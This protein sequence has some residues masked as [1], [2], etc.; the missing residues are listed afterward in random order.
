MTVEARSRLSKSGYSAVAGWVKHP[1]VR[2]AAA[3]FKA[4]FGGLDVDEDTQTFVVRLCMTVYRP[5]RVIGASPDLAEAL[6]PAQAMMEVDAEAAS[7]TRELTLSASQMASATKLV[8]VAASVVAQ[9][10]SNGVPIDSEHAPDVLAFLQLALCAGP[11]DWD[12]SGGELASRLVTGGPVLFTDDGRSM[13]LSDYAST[14]DTKDGDSIRVNE[15]RGPRRLP[16]PYAGGL[17]SRATTKVD[18]RRVALNEVVRKFPSVNSPSRIIA[19]FR[20]GSRD[21]P[22]GFFRDLLGVG[23][24]ECPCARTLRS[25][26]AAIRS[27]LPD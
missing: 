6:D 14:R 3:E 17:Q 11:A 19:S 2:I 5:T 12:L 8:D 24:W 16:A 15:I 18:R 22:G 4:G 10:Q 25:D 23:P 27:S 1:E 20:T 7:V 21:T 9:L 26:F 13:V